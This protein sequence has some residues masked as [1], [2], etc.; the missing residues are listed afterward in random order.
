MIIHASQRLPQAD[1]Q[2]K[3]VAHLYSFVRLTVP[4]SQP[5]NEIMSHIK[6]TYPSVEHTIPSAQM[7]LGPML[8]V[9]GARP[10]VTVGPMTFCP[11]EWAWNCTGDLWACLWTQ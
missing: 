4:N 9:V 5:P 1:S 3:A 7:V 2:T 11:L 10:T 6:I 8:A